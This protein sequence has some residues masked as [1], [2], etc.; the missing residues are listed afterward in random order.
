MFLWH[1]MSILLFIPDFNKV[2]IVFYSV[3]GHRTE[4]IHFESKSGIKSNF[5]LIEI[6]NKK[7][8]THVMPEKHLKITLFE[9][10]NKKRV[11]RREP[12]P[13]QQNPE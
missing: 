1:H 5:D 9:I 4:R 6:W 11:F 10:R 7:Q 13:R 12:P 3:F 2:E 8:N